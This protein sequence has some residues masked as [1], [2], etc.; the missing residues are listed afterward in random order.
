MDDGFVQLLFVLILMF[1]SLLDVVARGKRKRRGPTGELPREDVP[2]PEVRRPRRRPRGARAPGAPPGAPSPTSMPGAEGPRDR[3]E[4]ADTM[5]PEDLWAILTGQA[6]PTREPRPREPE[7]EAWSVEEDGW[8]AEGVPYPREGESTEAEAWRPEVTVEELPPAEAPAEVLPEDER[9][10]P[11]AP[12][13]WVLVPPEVRPGTVPGRAAAP[14]PRRP[15]APAI[16]PSAPLAAHPARRSPAA[17]YADLLRTGGV[18]SLRTAVVLRE[19]LDPPV[20]LRGS[21]GGFRA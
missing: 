21:R 1:A 19:V 20:A 5:V 10:R 11:S 7:G 14:T 12:P 2:P 4:T 16:G 8:T 3:R 9:R 15:I 6:P 18:D 17:R 13:P